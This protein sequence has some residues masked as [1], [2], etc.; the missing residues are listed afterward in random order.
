MVPGYVPHLV[1]CWLLTKVWMGSLGH[2]Q[3]QVSSCQT[4]PSLRCT[5]PRLAAEPSGHRA[6]LPSI[7]PRPRTRCPAHEEPLP[8]VPSP[9][10]PLP[11]GEG[12]GQGSGSSVG[13]V[14]GRLALASFLTL[15]PPLL[16]SQ[17]PHPPGPAHGQQLPGLGA[18]PSSGPTKFG[19]SP[20][21]LG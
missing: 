7:P 17:G 10:T 20:S 16:S 9:C 3:V 1:R 4:L 12:A 5:G 14:C 8:V 19:S 2:G 18:E 6:A 11:G 21:C 13:K 15:C